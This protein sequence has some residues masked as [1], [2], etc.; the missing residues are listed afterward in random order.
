MY[1][2]FLSLRY[3]RMRHTNWIG[4][5]G[6]AVGVLALIFILSIMTGFLGETRRIVRGTLSD[7]IIEPRSDVARGGKRLPD[8]PDQALALIR[9]SE[10]VAGTCAQIQHKGLIQRDGG[11]VITRNAGGVGA[12]AVQLIGSTQQTSTRRRSC[13]KRSSP[14]VCPRATASPTS[15]TRSRLRPVTTPRDGTRDRSRAC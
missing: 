5:A 12:S 2:G 9:E 13:A 7:V 3:L 8:A 6:I 10:T 4:M 14:T 1:R 11:A 15:T